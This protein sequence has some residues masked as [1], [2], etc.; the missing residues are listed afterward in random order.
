M[1]FTRLIELAA[2]LHCFSP[3]MVTAGDDIDQVRVQLSRWVKSGRVIRLHKGWYTLSEP[4]RHVRIDLHVIACTIKPGTYVSLQSAL[5]FHGM[6]PEHVPETTCVITGRPLTID[7]PFGRI[8]YRHIKEEVFFGY[9]RHV[10]G[11]QDAYVAVPEKALLDLFYLTPGSEDSD[12]LSELRLQGVED[13][14]VQ[15]MLRMARKFQA[16]RLERSVD[17]VSR[18]AE[19]GSY[20]Q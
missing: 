2:D 1:V 11:V 8:R 15:S 20:L 16:K 5:A 7:T 6:I 4:Y 14:D 13:F 9:S 17:L 10:H 12:Y 18:L 19:Q 3:G